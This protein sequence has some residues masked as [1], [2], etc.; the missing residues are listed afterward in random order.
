MVL[1]PLPVLWANSLMGSR[2]GESDPFER[3][4]RSRST[5]CSPLQRLF[6]GIGAAR[7]GAVGE[8]GQ[9]EGAPGYRVG[10]RYDA[11]PDENLEGIKALSQPHP[12][13]ETFDPK[14]DPAHPTR[15]S[16]MESK[17]SKFHALPN[18]AARQL[19]IKEFAHKALAIPSF[20]E[21]KESKGV[22][23]L[24]EKNQ[25]SVFRSPRC[26]QT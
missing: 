26:F 25:I 3:F 21:I 15:P 19:P 24:S 11:A 6:P 13:K 5:F 12:R 2:V 4:Y 18:I 8:L 17:I 10:K 20:F 14:A 22:R 16:V 7:H 1:A 9:S 23:M